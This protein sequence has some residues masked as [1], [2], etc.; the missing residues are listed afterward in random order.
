ML[1]QFSTFNRN[2]RSSL[3]FSASISALCNRNGRIITAFQSALRLGSTAPKLRLV[4][5]ADD[6]TRLARFLPE[7]YGELESEVPL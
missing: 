3:L 4:P 7:S 5:E 1:A 6:S 2:E